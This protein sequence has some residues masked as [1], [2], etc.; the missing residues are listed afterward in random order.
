MTVKQTIRILILL[1]DGTKFW[2]SSLKEQFTYD[3]CTGRDRVYPKCR[4]K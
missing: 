4:V 1:L 2:S 3:I